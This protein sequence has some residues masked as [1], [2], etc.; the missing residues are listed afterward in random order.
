MSALRFT[1]GPKNSRRGQAVVEVT[2]R[3]Q[4]L[5]LTAAEFILT[6]FGCVS[7]SSERELGMVT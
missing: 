6:V 4:N 2:S 3:C 5:C 7:M 1:P